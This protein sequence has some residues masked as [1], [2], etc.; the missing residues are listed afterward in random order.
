M[1]GVPGS[2]SPDPLSDGP[3]LHVGTPNGV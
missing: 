3:G 2:S 1:R